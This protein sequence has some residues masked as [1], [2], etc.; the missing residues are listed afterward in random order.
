MRE[1]TR[2]REALRESR[3]GA[4]SARDNDRERG[5]ERDQEREAASKQVSIAPMCI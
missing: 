5:K 2:E 3:G 4:V 1:I